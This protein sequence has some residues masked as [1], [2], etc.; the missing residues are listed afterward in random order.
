VNGPAVPHPT[1]ACAPG[2][3]KAR[4]TSHRPTLTV[5][6]GL[7][8][9]Y[10]RFIASLLAALAIVAITGAPARAS[11]ATKEEMLERIDTIS[12]IA[13][14]ASVSADRAVRGGVVD[15]IARHGDLSRAEA[16]VV[17]DAATDTVLS[18]TA[19]G[20]R[21]GVV[22]APDVDTAYATV[23]A[24]AGT[25]DPAAGRALAKVAHRR[26][27]ASE[28]SA[29]AD[30][31]EAAT[32]TAITSSRSRTFVPDVERWRPLVERYFPLDRVNEALA[33]MACESEGDPTAENRR[34]G[35]GG[36]FQFLDGTWAHA[37]AGAGFDGASV[38]SPVAN[39]ASAAWL[40]ESSIASGHDAWQQ[41]SCAP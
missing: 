29:R 27:A 8:M 19:I 11:G 6:M 10:P 26:V 25:A 18:L 34:S 39:I 2:L 40:V 13:R 37:S 35:A 15:L 23:L 36:L 30:R 5:L 1:V 28:A 4:V 24:F 38:F 22:T 17:L 31:I 20:E 12:E 32:L 16:G 41:W 9:R 7:P 21:S 14:R 3:R 33:V